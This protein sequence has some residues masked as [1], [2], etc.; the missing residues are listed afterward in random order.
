M[1][2]HD[3]DEDEKL[4]E[5][6]APPKPKMSVL[7]R[8]RILSDDVRRVI[9]HL[10]AHGK[11]T[12]DDILNRPRLKKKKGE[13][14][15]EEIPWAHAELSGSWQQKDLKPG[16]N[17]TA[18]LYCKEHGIWKRVV[19]EEEIEK[20]L[21][22]SMLDPASTMPLGRDSAYHHVQKSTVG[23]SRRSL[24]K[25]LERQGV[26]QV[27][28]NIPNE[29]PK[30]GILLT[31]RG[32]CEMDLIEGKGTDLY[33]NF[34]A[35]GDWYWLS[36]VEVLTGYGLVIVSRRKL[37]PMIADKLR[38]LLNLMEQR[39]GSEVYEI[40]ADHGREFFADVKRLLKRRK[41]KLTLLP[42]GSRVEK[43]N[44]DFQRNFYR[45]LR[46]RRGN[47]SS[48]EDQALALTNNTKNKNTK[49]TPEEALDTADAEL[50]PKYNDKRAQREPF[51]GREP[52][53]GDKCRH[54]IK[55]RKN[56]RPMLK[57]GKVNRLYKS[58]HGRHFSK[59]V[60]RITRVLER[61]E[62]K[63]GPGGE[64]ALKKR[65][66][67]VPKRYLVNGQWRNRDQII[68]VSGTDAETERQIAARPKRGGN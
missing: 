5:P 10:K 33:K 7:R 52:Q 12:K 38:Q 55:L 21:R 40:G 39:L 51:K 63:K 4:A 23:V 31:K 8:H 44:Q 53:V 64:D 46:M 68:L 27:S 50:V 61:S 24:Y 54:L 48:L 30:G 35:R 2:V 58:Y 18:V 41:I 65:G 29:Q 49:K 13:G 45:L 22:K 3:G 34:G 11:I 60:H 59:Q 36:L 37:A 6:P 26:L 19:A 57:I 16:P 9:A 62:P 56:M 14:P 15:N 28:K 25:F 42:R 43:F 47:F 20:Y 32:Y 66:G 67:Q 1:N 17:N